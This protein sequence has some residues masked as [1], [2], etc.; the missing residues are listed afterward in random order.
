M[1]RLILKSQKAFTLLEMLIVVAI[2]AMLAAIVFPVFSRARENARRSTCQSN[3]KQIGLAFQQYVSDSDGMIAPKTLGSNTPKQVSWPSMIVPYTKSTQVF[4]CPSQTTNDFWTA[5]NPRF[6]D[7]NAGSTKKPRYCGYS[8]GDVTSG[9]SAAPFYRKPITYSRNLI[10]SKS[11]INR[12]FIRCKSGFLAVSATSTTSGPVLHEAAVEDPS[13]TIHI[14]DAMTGGTNT[15][16][17]PCGGGASAMI[18]I[19]GEVNTDLFPNAESS[20]PAYRHLDGFN[21]LYGD[22]HVKWRQWGS[23]KIGEWSIQAGD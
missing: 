12:S 5:P 16:N 20:K 9:D 4:V 2:V 15:A 22:G 7:V 3:L 19:D 1:K 10:V 18:S 6:I 17:S 8:H 11:W 13:G 23:T 14:I 21:A